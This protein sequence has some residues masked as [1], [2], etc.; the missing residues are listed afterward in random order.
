MEVVEWE[1]ERA[2]GVKHSGIVTGIGRF[3]LTPTSDGTRFGQYESIELPLR[4]GGRL[5]REHRQTTS[6]SDFGETLGRFE[7]R[8]FIDRKR[9]Q[10]KGSGV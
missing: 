3:L 10:A 7:N 5:E 6:D 2:M 4:F 9:E 8:L 1:P